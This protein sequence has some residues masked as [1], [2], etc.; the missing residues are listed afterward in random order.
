MSTTPTEDPLYQVFEEHLHSGLYDDTPVDQFIRDVVDFYWRRLT[1][2]GHVPHRLQEP[3]RMD[4][5]Q[6]VQEMLKAKTYGNFGIGEYNRIR[7]K[8][9]S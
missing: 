4:L 8:K 7:R 2:A 5:L 9:T 6:D 1:M 3:L